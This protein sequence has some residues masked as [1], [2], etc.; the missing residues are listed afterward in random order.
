S[1]DPS[2]EGDSPPR[3]T[4]CQESPPR[5]CTAH[6]VS[7]GVPWCDLDPSGDLARSRC[8]TDLL[9]QDAASWVGSPCRL[10]ARDQGHENMM[11]NVKNLCEGPIPGSPSPGGSWDDAGR[12]SPQLGCGWGK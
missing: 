8:T 11:A 6:P 7:L 10:P 12:R 5:C 4:S 1:N 2:T 9:P 3:A